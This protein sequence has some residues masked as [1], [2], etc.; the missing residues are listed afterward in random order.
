MFAIVA[1]GGKQF[2][3]AEGDI[4]DVQRMDG[5]VGAQVELGPVLMAGAGEE[6]QIGAPVLDSAKVTAQIL[7]QAKGPKVITFKGRKR[8]D[9]RTKKGSRQMITTVKIVSIK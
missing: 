5:E 4:I 1:A 3:V 8:K 7:A 6:I 9:S 2:K